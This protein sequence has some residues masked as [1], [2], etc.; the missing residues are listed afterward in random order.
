MGLYDFTFYDLIC[1]NAV[2]FKEKSAWF[3]ALD[4]RSLTFSETL[5]TALKEA[6]KNAENANRLPQKKN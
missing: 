1:R 3:E 4:G 5:L 2:C 6:A